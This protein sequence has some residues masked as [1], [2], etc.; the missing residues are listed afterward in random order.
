MCIDWDFLEKYTPEKYR[1]FE[2]LHYDYSQVSVLGP[3]SLLG[4]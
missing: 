2:Q 4:S 3:H 1:G